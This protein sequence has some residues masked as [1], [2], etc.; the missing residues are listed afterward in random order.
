MHR[1]HPQV[2]FLLQSRAHWHCLAGVCPCSSG[3]LH[4]EPAARL[5]A[6]SAWLGGQLRPG[7]AELSTLLSM[8]GARGYASAPA[9]D[10]AGGSVP[11]NAVDIK[12]E[13]FWDLDACTLAKVDSSLSL[14]GLRGQINIGMS[15][16]GHAGMFD[17]V[18]AD[19]GCISITRKLWCSVLVLWFCLEKLIIQM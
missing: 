12:Q 16:A 14:K 3:A 13:H 5:K 11:V 18:D 9:R 1:W 10:E 2:V 15:K 4:A 17:A 19:Q 8:E 6:N 7:L